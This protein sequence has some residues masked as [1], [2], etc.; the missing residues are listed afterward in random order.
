MKPKIMP[1]YEVYE[2]EWPAVSFITRWERE[3]VFLLLL[4]IWCFAPSW[5]RLADRTTGSVDQSIWLLILLSLLS[6]LLI[7][8]LVWWLLQRS[9]ARLKLPSIGLIVS[10]FKSLTPWQQLGFYWASYALLL[11]AALGCL[12]ALC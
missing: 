7:A 8:A 4:F 11:L 6:F 9:W 10:H 5:L 3:L 12:M 2:P 1:L